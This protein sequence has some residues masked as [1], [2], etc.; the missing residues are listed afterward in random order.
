MIQ[1]TLAAGFR[2][3]GDVFFPFSFCMTLLLF[4]VKINSILAAGF[5][6]CSPGGTFVFVVFVFYS[7]VRH[8]ESLS[9]LQ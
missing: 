8:F 3:L 5:K 1:G 2:D 9:L 6:D 4:T 7:E